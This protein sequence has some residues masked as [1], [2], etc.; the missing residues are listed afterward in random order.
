MS[1]SAQAAYHVLASEVAIV[2][3]SEMDSPPAP[4]SLAF[5]F[6]VLVAGAKFAGLQFQNS[7]C[8]HIR[9]VQDNAGKWDEVLPSTPL[10]LH[11]YADALELE[12]W[13]FVPVSML[14]PAWRREPM[15][16]FR[17]HVQYRAVE[18]VLAHQLRHVRCLKLAPA[19]ALPPSPR[20]HG[21][22]AGT[23][24][25]GRDINPAGRRDC[26]ADEAMLL[27]EFLAQRAKA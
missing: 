14:T 3:D 8:S 23:P 20:S 10:L 4:G 21:D 2:E 24:N 7:A 22:D 27:S 17:V 9:I 11:D 15:C 16:H 6:D 25:A 26:V 1:R 12:A 5:C 19:D 18:G 13:H